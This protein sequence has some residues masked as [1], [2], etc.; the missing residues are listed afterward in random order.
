MP[1]TSIRTRYPVTLS[2]LPLRTGTLADIRMAL[3]P[4]DY[5]SRSRRVCRWSDHRAALLKEPVW[6]ITGRTF[7]RLHILLVTPRTN[8]RRLRAY[9]TYEQMTALRTAAIAQWQRLPGGQEIEH[10]AA[11]MFPRELKLEADETVDKTKP[12]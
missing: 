2:A 10:L 9:G 6:A 3:Y 8:S 7:D 1:A 4:P 5:R 12:A 11:I